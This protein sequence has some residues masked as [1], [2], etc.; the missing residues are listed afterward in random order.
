[1]AADL[2]LVVDAAERHAGE[3]ASQRARDQLA[4]RR[5]AH[6]GRAHQRDD[7]A[8]AAAAE[9]G[10]T[11]LTAQLAHREELDDPLLHVVETGVVR[12]EDA[13]RLCEVEVVVGAH[14]PGD[15]EHPVQVRPDPAVLGVLLAG[16][17]EAVELA[18][19]LLAHVLG[20]AR[21]LEPL[22]VV[23]GDVVATLAELL[24]DRL[25]LLAQQ[26]VALRLLHALVDLAADPSRAPT[27]RRGCPWSTR[28]AASAAA[29]R[30]VVSSSS[31]LLLGAEVGRVA[32]EVGE[33]A[34]MT[35]GADHL[36]HPAGTTRTR[37]GSRSGARYSRASSGPRRRARRPAAA[38]PAPRARRRCRTGHHRGGR[39]AGP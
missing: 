3:L 14:V 39:G 28:S 36:D 22:A 4:E 13:A 11:A 7:R 15:L 5:L 8:R 29:R 27:R 34:G 1:M 31:T 12:V 19:D 30:R 9:H 20:H 2:G 18:L 10:E 17:L 37:G 33:L 6:P 16:A 26:V 35:H 23:G 38:R 24:L 21:L 25:D 32:G